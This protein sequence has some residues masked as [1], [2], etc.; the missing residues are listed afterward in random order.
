MWYED[1]WTGQSGYAVATATTPQG[2]FV[3]V[4]NS[5]DMAP[6]GG[7]IGDYDIFIGPWG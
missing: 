4:A 7:R 6:G 1:R 3:T 2:P 5:V